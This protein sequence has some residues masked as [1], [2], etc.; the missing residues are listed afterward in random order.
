MTK[1]FYK[2]VKHKQQT[3]IEI[4]PILSFTIWYFAGKII[5]CTHEG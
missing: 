5:I 2:V 4:W 3:F 1:T